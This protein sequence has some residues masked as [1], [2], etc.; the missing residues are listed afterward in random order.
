MSGIPQLSFSRA[1][2]LALAPQLIYTRSALIPTLVSSKVHTQLEFLAVGTWWI[3]SEN[4]LRKIPGGR[5]DIFADKTIDLK[6]KRALMKF[7]R[8]AA[9][10]DA[11]KA[12]LEDW[13]SRPIEDLLT[14]HYEI[15][16]QL[17]E[18]LVAL[19]LS[20]KGPRDTLVSFA[21]PRITR[22]LT[23]IGIFGPGFGSVIPKWGGLAEI[24]QVGCRAGAVGGGVYVLGNGVEKLIS[25][26]T[27]QGDSKLRLG[28]KTGDTVT[29]SWITGSSTDFPE[30]TIED[31]PRYT[32]MAHS[33]FI[34][35]S[36]LAQLFPP[37][38]DGAQPPAATVVVYPVGTVTRNFRENA[39]P[40]YMTIHSSDTGECPAGQCKFPL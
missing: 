16:P 19:T 25:D 32:H 5:E 13:G 33:I 39:V 9:T 23:S 17:Q 37:V 22:H 14:Q 4:G 24:A 29:T 3:C 34:V 35:S 11:K 2:S 27:S 30:A 7:L 8:L 38:A 1:Y 20:S 15:P 12:L 36:A 40:I 28:L 6:S 18:F 26:K 21:R 31:C 10:A